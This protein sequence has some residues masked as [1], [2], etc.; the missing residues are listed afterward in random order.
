M[1]QLKEIK[2]L[3]DYFIELDRRETK[4]VYFSRINGFSDEIGTFLLK[5]YEEAR[6]YGVV[7]EGRIP[8]PSGQNLEYF[9][10][11]MG[12]DFQL[13][14]KFLSDNL[15]KWL[16]RLNGVQH[17]YVSQS[18]FD[19]LCQ[20]K[21]T[22]KTDSMLRNT[23]IKFM[24]WLYYKFE[25]ILNQLGQTHLPKIL[26]EGSIS[27]Y[28]LML[29]SILSNAGCDVVLLQYEGDLAYRTID[30]ND[31]YSKNLHCMGMGPF[32]AGYHLGYIREQIQKKQNL[33]RLY[34]DTCTIKR[35]TNRWGFNADVNWLDVLK[36]E[37]KRGQEKNCFYNMF[38]RID[39]VE[40]K[41]TYVNTLYQ[42]QQE[43]KSSRRGLVILNH[44]IP[45]PEPEEIASIRRRPYSSVE[46]LIADLSLNLLPVS[47]RELQQLMRASFAEIIL[48]LADKETN[49][50]RLLNKAVYLL[51]WLRRYQN[52]LF[53]NWKLSQTGCFILFGG[54]QTETEL[55][56]LKFLSR[57]P[58]DV[59][60]LCPQQNAKEF[61]RNED[62]FFVI[63]YSDS[64]ELNHY[65]E[66]AASARIGTAAYHAEREL[67]T[68]LYENTGLY[69]NQQYGKANAITLQTM[70]EEIRI[71]WNEELKY[72]PG[73]GV[74]HNI[75]NMPVI[76]SKVSGV[77][78]G[79]VSAYW[80]S[81]K[82]L[83]SQDTIVIKETP[84]V[85]HLT[86]N[87]MKAAA[88]TFYKNGRL[89]R[90]K[91]KEHPNYPYRLLRQEIQEMMLDT[92]DWLICS[93]VIKGIGVN[94]ME[95]TVISTVLSL[96]KEIIRLLQKFDYTKKNPKLIYILSGEQAV[97][98]EDAILTAFLNRMGFDI[99][100]FVPTGYQC[101]EAYF[102][103]NIMEE[104]QIGEYLYD[105]CI[106]DFDL[107]SSGA[108]RQSWRER[109][110]K[111]GD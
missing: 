28:E 15:K 20:M 1:L 61:D 108:V 47:N 42:L 70:Y 77:K 45:V 43:L 9:Y 27:S 55:W 105:L 78:D 10:E 98:P 79:R 8:S 34:G 2:D 62:D 107:I 83:I 94:G 92:L 110:F 22:G 50:N 59:L 85:S 38:L 66:D 57:L 23:Y 13:D 80:A 102:T 51:C 18:F 52:R 14:S 97:S 90:E 16:P 58:V 6:R 46:Q 4:C 65:P 19:L 76:F 24:C 72:R 111:K 39:G 63:R 60:M 54:C 32:P 96:P 41:M 88:A 74:N 48:E 82:A 69:R 68:L 109:I 37:A 29:I 11:M 87:P 33:Q 31:V 53:A 56:F 30:P 106:P 17:S 25:R 35:Y 101:V 40:D 67:D 71:L 99:V 86:V 93:R 104:H 89:L 100:F 12:T 7:I 3:N 91:I 64:L 44:T 103:D 81:I 21:E 95:Y 73:F 36:N 84:Y 26:Y 5:Y 49:G 75:V